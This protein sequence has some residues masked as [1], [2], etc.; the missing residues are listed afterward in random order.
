[1]LVWRGRRGRLAQQARRER[2]EFKEFKEFKAFKESRDLLARQAQP[3]RREQ[4]VPSRDLS[5]A[6]ATTSL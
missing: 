2:K 1:V 4:L 6:E 5:L 3:G